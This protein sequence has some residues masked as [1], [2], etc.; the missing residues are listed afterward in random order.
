MGV[1]KVYWKGLRLFLHSTERYIERN[2]AG[3]EA[4]LTA[5]QFACVQAVLAAIIECLNSLPVNTPE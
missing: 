2:D 1:R 4:S 3:L 5:P